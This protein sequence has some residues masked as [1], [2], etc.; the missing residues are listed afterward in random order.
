MNS[1]PSTHRALE[2]PTIEPLTRALEQG[3]AERL[4]PGAA[5]ALYQHGELLHLSCTGAAQLLPEWRS[6]TLETHFDLASL[7]KILATAP[8]VLRLCALGLL[9][10]DER[11]ARY[12]PGFASGGKGEVTVRHLL[13]HTS[14]LAPYRPLYLT[15]DGGLRK[16]GAEE[17]ERLLEQ[18]PLEA[19]PGERALYC[20]LGFMALGLLV[21]RVAREPLEQ[22]V[23]RELFEPLGLVTLGYRPLDGRPLPQVS[24]AAT[25]LTRPRE[26]AP[27]QPPLPETIALRPSSPGE[28]DD[29]NAY[30]MGGV[31][32]HAGL[33]GTAQEVALFG[34]RILDELNGAGRLGAKA[35]WEEFARRQGP[36]GSTRALGFDTPSESGSSVGTR[37]AREGTLGHL[38]F[39]G[40]SLWLD[41]GRQLSIAL[42]TNRT[43]PSRANE[44]LKL[45]RPRFHD[46]VA[47]AVDTRRTK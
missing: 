26:P 22:F 16:G 34:A 12:W 31:A 41:R 8:A 30:L 24:L 47:E 38:G 32:G 44:G 42:L 28:V 40:T 27:G 14:G 39:T 13:A 7:T 43:H 1:P 37:M 33:F 29:D 45:F 3:V 18:E 35:L 10:L 6:L 4:F 20:D 17:V 19:A 25:G 5:A 11:V 46:A 2:A 23:W 21:E 15:L 36:S 9:E